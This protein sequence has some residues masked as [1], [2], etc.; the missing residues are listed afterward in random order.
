MAGSGEE[1]YMDV[2]AVR[3]IG[4]QFG[5]IGE[6]LKQVAKALEALSNM[7]KVAAAIGLVGAAVV[8]AFIDMIRPHIEKLAQKCEELKK[9][10]LA[11]AQAY[12]NGDRLG[13]AR[14]H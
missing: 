2:P 12:E 11:S 14:F 9:D 7:C 5:N 13:S 8:K 10:V 1:V 6:V 4:N 3:E